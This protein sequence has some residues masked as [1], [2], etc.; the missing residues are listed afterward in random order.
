MLYG[1]PRTVIAARILISHIIGMIFLGIYGAFGANGGFVGGA[2][3]MSFL[4]GLF[5]LPFIVVTLLFVA[6]GWRK[7]YAHPYV[8]AVVGPILVCLIFWVFLGESGLLDLVAIAT[9]TST[10]VFAAL[11]YFN[12]PYLRMEPRSERYCDPRDG[13][14]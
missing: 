4:G 5:S 3:L 7:I 12:K 14:F 9:F 10:L 1:S 11:V 2:L 6:I 13:Y 8:F